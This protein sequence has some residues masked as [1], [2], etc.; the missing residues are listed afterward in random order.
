MAAAA[1]MTPVFSPRYLGRDPDVASVVSDGQRVHVGAQGQPWTFTSIAVPRSRPCAR[2]PCECPEPDLRC[3][4]HLACGARLAIAI[5]MRVIITPPC[6]H[7]F[8]CDIGRRIGCLSSRRHLV[9]ASVGHA[10]RQ[11]RERKAAS[12]NPDRVAMSNDLPRRFIG[13]R[14]MQRIRLAPQG[15]C[16]RARY[17]VDCI[18]SVLRAARTARPSRP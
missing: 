18:R 7:L 6:E 16:S 8:G 9:P 2:T 12:G 4:G 5:G 1:C 15:R 13:S 3:V 17:V 11:Q 14:S 10:C